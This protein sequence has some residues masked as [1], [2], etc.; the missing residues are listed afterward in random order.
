MITASIPELL[1]LCAEETLGS[2]FFTP[3]L[4]PFEAGSEQPYLR[5]RLCFLGGA[6]RAGHSDAAAPGG[7]LDIEVSREAA[8]SIAANFLA[9]DEGS[10]PEHRVDDVLCELANIICGNVMSAIASKAGFSLLSPE[11]IRDSGE[12]WPEAQRFQESFELERGWLTV[13]LA[14]TNA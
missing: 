13:R 5:V 10:V 6:S 12:E 9:A 8:D 4:G 3:I 11:I 7:H 1:S 2:M 14:L